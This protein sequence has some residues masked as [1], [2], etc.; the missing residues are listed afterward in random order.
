MDERLKKLLG[1]AVE[2]VIRTGE[3]VGS[4]RMVEAYGLEVSPATV[5]NWFGE[6]EDLGCLT[7]PHTSSGRVPTEKGYRLYVDEIMLKKQLPKRDAQDLDKALSAEDLSD[8]CKK[9]AAK[10]AAEITNGAVVLGLRRSD[11]YYTGLSHLFAQPEFS[12][13]QHV[14]NFGNILDTLDDM[15]QR[16]RQEAYV[17]PDIRLGRECPFGSMCGSVLLTLG[18]GTL[19]GILGPMRMDYALAKSVLLHV[20]QKLK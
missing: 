16:V 1:L 3:P 17:E 2:D 13:W 14:V 20:K 7:H 11:T 10:C 5:R 6:L 4:Q 8:E 15:L 9:A 12:D 19:F 18:D